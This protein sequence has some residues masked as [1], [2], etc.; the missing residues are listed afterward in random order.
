[1]DAAF[2]RVP[3]LSADPAPA[4]KLLNSE[5]A[6]GRANGYAAK[7]AELI[8][9][10]VEALHARATLKASGKLSP[11]ASEAANTAAD[12]AYLDTVTKLLSKLPKP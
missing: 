2:W 8:V 3:G 7:H 5:I 6:A 11:L 10:Y 4:G 1:M 12:K 9:R